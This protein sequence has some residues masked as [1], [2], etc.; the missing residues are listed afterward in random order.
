MPQIGLYIRQEAPCDPT[1]PRTPSMPWRSPQP[2]FVPSFEKQ[3]RSK[4]YFRNSVVSPGNDDPKGAQS[5]PH[6][7]SLVQIRVTMTRRWQW[8]SWDTQHTHPNLSCSLLLDSCTEGMFRAWIK[9]ENSYKKWISLAKPI[10]VMSLEATCC[11]TSPRLVRKEVKWGFLAE[12]KLV[13]R[14]QILPFLHFP[15]CH[16]LCPLCADRLDWF[17]KSLGSLTV[18]FLWWMRKELEYVQQH[19]LKAEFC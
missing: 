19:S 7:L 3:H 1:A 11:F 4:K 17:E 6:E 5:P 8:H 18:Q 10:G 15:G 9:K 14:G 13:L 2:K 12:K 16:L